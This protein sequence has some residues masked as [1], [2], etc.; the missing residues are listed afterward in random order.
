MSS[1]FMR[2]LTQPL[3]SYPRS[4][5][6][7]V[8]F[9]AAPLPVGGISFTGWWSSSFAWRCS[10]PAETPPEHVSPGPSGLAGILQALVTRHCHFSPSRLACLSHF[11]PPAPNV[12]PGL[13]WSRYIFV[14]R[15]DEWIQRNVTH[16]PCAHEAYILVGRETQ[17]HEDWIIKQ[18][19][20]RTLV[21][22]TRSMW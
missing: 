22:L 21:L 19:K 7:W 10:G 16:T 11:C 20:M 5:E 15:M 14:E 13:R 6:N 4:Q 9:V 8:S 2:E 3:C 1:W 12:V 17:L 18:D